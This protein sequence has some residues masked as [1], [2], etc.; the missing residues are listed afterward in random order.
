MRRTT[1]ILRFTLRATTS[2]L[3]LVATVGLAAIAV[4]PSVGCQALTVTS[5]SMRPSIDP[6][7]LAFVCEEDPASIEAGD[8]I[9]FNGYGA[10]HLTTH[11]VLSRDPVEGRLHFRTQGDANESPDADLAPAAGVVGRVERVVPRAGYVLGYLRVPWVR[12]LLLGVP[13]ALTAVRAVRALATGATG[14][15]G[16]DGGAERPSRRDEPVIPDAGRRKRIRALGVTVALTLVAAS[17]VVA[18]S[19]ALLAESDTVPDNSFSTSS[20]FT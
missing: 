18:G 1:A 17:G 4:G 9:T 14:A 16:G 12:G 8:V 13:A 20:T 15:A 3:L 7:D 6:G 10:E 2:L 11:R 5:G 19:R